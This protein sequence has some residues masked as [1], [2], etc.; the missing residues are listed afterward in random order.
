MDSITM[1]IFAVVFVLQTVTICI[2]VAYV[3]HTKRRFT[4]ILDYIDRVN[5][6]ACGAMET[7][8]NELRKEFRKQEAERR[9]ENEELIF[10]FTHRL[11]EEV[12]KFQSTI[13]TLKLDFIQA[14]EAANKINDFGASLA[15]IFD[16]DPVRALQKSRSKEAS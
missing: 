6:G 14:Q 11:Q 12:Q 9:K 8:V 3:I 4:A 10:K 13:D 15:N 1:I 16:Y 5:D 2:S 7:D